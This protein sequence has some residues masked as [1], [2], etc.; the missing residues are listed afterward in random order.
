MPEL[1]PPSRSQAVPHEA[2]VCE[3]VE[4]RE[5]VDGRHPHLV[6]P[7]ADLDLLKPR[8]GERRFEVRRVD[9]PFLQRRHG[10]LCRKER[11]SADHRFRSPLPGPVGDIRTA[12]TLRRR[13]YTEATTRL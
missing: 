1:V 4:H 12:W 10:A 11:F 13:R 8:A 5:V 3:H 2:T 9:E 7:L 6:L